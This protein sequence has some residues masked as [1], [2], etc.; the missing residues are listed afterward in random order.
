[1]SGGHILGL[2]GLMWDDNWEGEPSMYTLGGPILDWS[3]PE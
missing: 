1:M 2:M 3:D